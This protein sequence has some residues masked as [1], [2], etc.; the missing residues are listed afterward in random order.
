MDSAGIPKKGLGHFYA[1]GVSSGTATLN[2]F[3]GTQ[4]FTRAHSSALLLVAKWGTAASAGVP[5]ACRAPR[6][7]KGEGLPLHPLGFY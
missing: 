3:P 7:L 6:P 1:F 4:E 2:L 5:K